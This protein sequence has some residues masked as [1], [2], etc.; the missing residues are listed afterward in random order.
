MSCNMNDNVDNIKIIVVFYRLL[1]KKES[2]I[3]YRVD[4]KGENN[5]G[6][7]SSRSLHYHINCVY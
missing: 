7:C 4:R 2:I 5:Y 6:N 1:K 3:E